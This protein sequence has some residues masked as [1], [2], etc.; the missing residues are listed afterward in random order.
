[1][2]NE[3]ISALAKQKILSRLCASSSICTV[4]HLLGL[5]ISIGYPGSLHPLDVCSCI[6]ASSHQAGAVTLLSV[7][8][9]LTHELKLLRRIPK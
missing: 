7:A 2:K 1:M 6:A 4:V 8:L 9:W 3:C 5:F